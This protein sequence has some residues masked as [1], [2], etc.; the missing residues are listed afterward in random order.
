MSHKVEMSR[1]SWC[2]GVGVWG[3]GGVEGWNAA[4]PGSQ[5]SGGKPVPR[6]PARVLEQ[7]GKFWRGSEER[8][9]AARLQTTAE[10][11]GSNYCGSAAWADA[12]VQRRL[13]QPD[14]SHQHTLSCSTLTG[15]TWS[16]A[17]H[18]GGESNPPQDPPTTHQTR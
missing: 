2:G 18:N 6:R 12:P 11:R 9:C 10:R 17:G 14:L 1:R 5:E 3:C 7:Q 16:N 13:P 15:A 4:A 8:E